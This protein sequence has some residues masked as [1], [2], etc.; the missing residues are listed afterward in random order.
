MFKRSPLKNGLLE[1]KSQNKE[2]VV[3]DGALDKSGHSGREKTGLG[4]FFGRWC[5]EDQLID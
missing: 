4:T 3:E 5:Q 2:V 1:S